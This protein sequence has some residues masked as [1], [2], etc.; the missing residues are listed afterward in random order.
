MLI[1]PAND[2]KRSANTEI[3]VEVHFSRY[4]ELGFIIPS[5]PSKMRIS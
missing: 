5:I 4:S 2:A 1:E 3:A